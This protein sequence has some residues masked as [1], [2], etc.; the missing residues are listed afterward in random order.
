[1]IAAL[2]S[3]ATRSARLLGRSKTA[4]LWAVAAIAGALLAV[5]ATRLA[6][7]EV[8]AWSHDLRPQAS[9]V[10]YLDEGATVDQA[11]ALATRLRGVGGVD[12]VAVVSADEAQQ[13]LRAALGARDQL[14][15]GVEADSLPISLELTLGAGV[16]EVAAGSPVVA[17]LRATAGVDEVEV[18]RDARAPLADALVR[19]TRL[20]WLLFLVVGVGA[21]VAVAA[22]IR[23]HLA[24]DRAA[25]ST[26]RLLGAG[27]WLT[28]APTVGAGIALGLLGAGLAVGVA[29]GLAAT[30]LAAGLLDP[31]LWTPTAVGAALAIGAALGLAGGVVAEARDA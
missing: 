11:E 1:M 24:A 26:L 28:R 8:G 23:L 30:D 10:V 16:A 9:M 18:T 31:A 29:R 5:G 20:A 14:L 2:S 19:L 3:F 21:V 13:R 17:E 6:A 22:A 12:A 25:R 27:P 4:T 15:D 7:R